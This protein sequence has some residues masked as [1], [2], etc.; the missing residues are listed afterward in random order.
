MSI[1]VE[2]GQCLVKQLLLSKNMQ[3]IDLSLRTGI[4]KTQLSGY[5]SGYRCMSLKSAKAIS[6]VLS[7]K[8]DDLCEPPTTKVAGF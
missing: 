1:Y 6:Y 4:S 5:L 2:V 7:C 8:I 3:I